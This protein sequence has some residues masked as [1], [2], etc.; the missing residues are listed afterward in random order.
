MR[1]RLEQSR[2]GELLQDDGRQGP[3]CRRPLGD[4][5]AQSALLGAGQRLRPRCL[6][7]DGARQSRSLPD[8]D[9]QEPPERAHLPR[10]PAQRSHGDS[11][12]A[13]LARARPGATVS[14]PLT[15]TQVTAALDPKRFTIRTA[16]ALMAKS[17]AWRD[18]GDG[19]RPLEQALKRLG[20]PRQAA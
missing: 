4:R 18:Y 2:P 9:D 5:Q 1:E 16:P 6:S 8:Q 15:W 20:K 14:M 19:Q 13:A 12:R 11:R 7:A 17:A 10:L 3:P